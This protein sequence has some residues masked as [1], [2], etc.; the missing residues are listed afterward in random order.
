MAVPAI[1]AAQAVREALGVL[2]ELLV[3]VGRPR[4]VVVVGHMAAVVE[5]DGL[6]VLVILEQV[7]VVQSVLFGPEPRAHS[8]Q[9]IQET[10]K[11]KPQSYIY[12]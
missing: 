11:W 2:M 5:P 6:P 12:R 1:R 9:R 4:V 8:R 10:Y 7:P 3:P